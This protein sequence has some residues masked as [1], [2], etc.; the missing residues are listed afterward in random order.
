MVCYAFQSQ[1]DQPGEKSKLLQ[2]AVSVIKC[3]KLSGRVLS[4][5]ITQG[6]INPMIHSA[7]VTSTKNRLTT[8]EDDVDIRWNQFI[9]VV[10]N[11]SV[12]CVKGNMACPYSR[13]TL[14]SIGSS[15]KHHV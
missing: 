10:S 15:M 4:F 11:G 9:C 7:D 8:T 6:I 13:P 5:I 12:R 3:I 14:V 1:V 2:G